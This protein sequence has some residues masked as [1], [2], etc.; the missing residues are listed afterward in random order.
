MAYG[1]RSKALTDFLSRY[2]DIS[3]TPFKAGILGLALVGMSPFVV[4]ADQK[5]SANPCNVSEADFAGLNGDLSADVHAI[6]IT[7]HHRS[8]AKGRKFQDS[9]IVSQTMRDQARKDFPADTGNPH[10][11]CGSGSS[12]SYLRMHATDE[13]GVPFC[14]GCR[15]GKRRAR[16][17]ISARVRI[18][19]GLHQLRLGR[20]RERYEWYS[21]RKRMDVFR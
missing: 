18:G 20:A 14:S 10:T 6:A 1:L 19:L 2:F 15:G 3:S 17:P 7:R 16:N 8:H 13:I 5:A 4:A 12:D 21:Q 11:V 9:S